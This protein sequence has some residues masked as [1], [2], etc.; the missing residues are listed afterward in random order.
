MHAT[1]KQKFLFISPAVFYLLAFTVYP[2]IYALGIS[3]TDLNLSRQGTGVFVGIRNY[4]NLFTGS[5]LFI[6]AL[7]NNF[8]VI[9]FGIIVQLVLGFII[10]RLFF[11][12]KD[13]YGINILRT[14]YIIP[15]MI[16]PLVFGLISSYIFNPMLGIAN[17]I[18]TSIGLTAQPWFGDP[19]T[20]LFTVIL[21]DTWQWTPFM[22][23]VLLAGLMGIPQ[24]LYE[25]AEVDGARLRHKIFL[26]EIP[27]IRRVIGIAVIM[28]LME[29]IRMF[30]LVY[31]TTRGGPGGATEIISMFAYRQAFNFYNTAVGSSAAIFALIL[32]VT[33]SMALNKYIKGEE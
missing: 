15:I 28:R 14:I 1:L 30:D 8:T 17:H 24:E 21:V 16:T 33:L 29:L 22:V 2:L 23:I 27:L 32:T 12:A 20:A 19:G 25:N 31:A 11:V 6:K 4:I 13:L 3:F 9:V 7:A 18:L 5:E 26:I 10:A